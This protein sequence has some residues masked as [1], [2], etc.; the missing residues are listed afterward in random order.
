M[1]STYAVLNDRLEVVNLVV[2]DGDTTVWG[3]PA[4]CTAEAVPE[5]AS[6]SIGYRLVDGVFIDPSPPP[7][8]QITATEVLAQRDALLTQAALR[9]AP[10]QDA[11][12]LGDATAT[13]EAA[14]KAWKQYRVKLMRIEQQ[15]GFP[16]SVVW[17]DAPT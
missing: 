11:V 6:V 9:I 16:T 15:S 10:L 7:V 14:L 1:G 4:G 17:P 5:G 8:P 13:E 12:D 3:P 2:W